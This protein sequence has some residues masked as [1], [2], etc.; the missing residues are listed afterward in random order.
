MAKYLQVASSYSW[1][2]TCN[3]YTVELRCTLWTI[4]GQVHLCLLR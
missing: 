1:L 3:L 4:Y 2:I